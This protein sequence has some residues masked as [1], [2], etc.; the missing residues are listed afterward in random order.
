MF[1]PFAREMTVAGYVK[2]LSRWLRW[3]LP[4]E[5]AEAIVA[6]TESHLAAR[7]D[8]LMATGRGP[9]R[10]RSGR[11]R[12]VWQRV[13]LQPRPRAKRPLT[14]VSRGGHVS[15]RRLLESSF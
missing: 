15:A 10:R 13:F 8:D 3:T 14:T 11:G 9:S 4:S 6:E 5:K 2:A 1:N 7:V 12:R